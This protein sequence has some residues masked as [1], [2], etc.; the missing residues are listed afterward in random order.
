[1]IQKIDPSPAFHEISVPAVF[2][3]M[4]KKCEFMSMGYISALTQASVLLG[5][6]VYH[7]RLRYFTGYHNC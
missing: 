7:N 4:Y 5:L 3:T 2:C 6:F 1:M